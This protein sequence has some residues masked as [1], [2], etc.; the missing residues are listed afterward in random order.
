MGK[1]VDSWYH[2]YLKLCQGQS[3]A[4]I[5]PKCSMGPILST[6]LFRMAVLHQCHMTGACHG[7]L[8]KYFRKKYKKENNFL[9]QSKKK[10]SVGSDYCRVLFLDYN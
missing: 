5:M 2:V 4:S 1:G 8:D 6:F 9:E 3:Q 10:N 7:K